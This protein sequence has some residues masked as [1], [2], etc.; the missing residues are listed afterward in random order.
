MTI[1]AL[2]SWELTL[3]QSF[4]ALL[5]MEEAKPHFPE[6][7]L[8]QL[9]DTNSLLNRIT[10]RYLTFCVDIKLIFCLECSGEYFSFGIAL[11]IGLPSFIT[12]ST[13]ELISPKL[14]TMRKVKMTVFWIK[15]FMF[16]GRHFAVF[17][18]AAAWKMILHPWK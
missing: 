4:K 1:R 5:Q 18:Y 10:N 7:T 15:F 14:C 9:Q 8:L 17:L 3:Q 16:V 2:R 6:V 13:W 11:F 12:H